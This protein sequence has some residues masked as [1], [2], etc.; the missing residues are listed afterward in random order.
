VFALGVPGVALS[1]TGAALWLW[2]AL[3]EKD[4]D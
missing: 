2:R 1:L 3:R 4:T